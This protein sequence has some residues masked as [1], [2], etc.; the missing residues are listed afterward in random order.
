MTEPYNF[1]LYCV[2]LYLCIYYLSAEFWLGNFIQCIIHQSKFILRREKND[3][4][5]FLPNYNW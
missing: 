4:D 2:N 1:Y 3:G 5:K